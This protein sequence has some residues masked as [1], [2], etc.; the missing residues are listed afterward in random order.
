MDKLNNQEMIDAGL[1]C[2]ARIQQKL[3]SLGEHSNAQILLGD[4]TDDFSSILVY[5]I[6]W[7]TAKISAL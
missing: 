7:R 1:L 2:S 3:V 5:R 4:D 6:T